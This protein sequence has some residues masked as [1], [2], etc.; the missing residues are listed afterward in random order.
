MNNNFISLYIILGAM[1][2]LLILTGIFLGNIINMLNIKINPT[3]L[4]IAEIAF[5]L[6]GIADIFLVIYAKKKLS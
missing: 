5:I 1:A 3:Y 6:S 4:H 2:I